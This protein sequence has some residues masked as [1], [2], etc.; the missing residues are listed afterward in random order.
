MGISSESHDLV[1][2]GEM[3]GMRGKRC[4]QLGVGHAELRASVQQPHGH[5]PSR[6][7]CTEAYNLRGIHIYVIIRTREKNVDG[8]EHMEQTEHCA[9]AQSWRE[10]P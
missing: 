3:E 9:P 1:N 4:M 8:G 5:G 2:R 7:F 10:R 6:Y